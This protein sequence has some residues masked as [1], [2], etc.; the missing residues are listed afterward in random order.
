MNQLKSN[1][2]KKMGIAMVKCYMYTQPTI[3]TS[4]WHQIFKFI[5]QHVCMC[6]V[7]YSWKFEAL[8]RDASIKGKIEISFVFNKY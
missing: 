4:V 2:C 1:S 7:N 8:I 5:V 6:N 3:N